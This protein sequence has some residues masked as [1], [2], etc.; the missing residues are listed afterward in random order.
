MVRRACVKL[1]LLVTFLIIVASPPAAG[2]QQSETPLDLVIVMDNSGSMDNEEFGEADP[3]GLR[4]DAAKMLID[5]LS[6]EDR[7]GLVQ[8]SDAATPLVEALK[9]LDTVEQRTTL[10]DVI[11]EADNEDPGNLTNYGVALAAAYELL[12]D[13]SRNQR[14]VIFL[15]DGLPSD[16]QDGNGQV[17][18]AKLDAALAPFK[19]TN[20]PVYLLLLENKLFEQIQDR[21]PLVL[22]R[23]E[24]TGASAVQLSQ[25]IDTAR[26]FAY[27]ITQLQPSTY[28]DLLTGDPE[29]ATTT[30][31][32]L[33]SSADQA[34]SQA[35]FVFVPQVPQSA[36][37]ATPLLE[38]SNSQRL[39]A[40]PD[41]NYSVVKYESTDNRPLEGDWQFSVN[42]QQVQGFA[43]VRSDVRLELVY[44][45]ATAEGHRYYARDQ[46]LFTAAR[47]QGSVI[48][49]DSRMVIRILPGK[50]CFVLPAGET[51]TVYPLTARGLSTDASLFWGII[52]P[53]TG[54]V[55]VV[56]EFQQLDRPLRLTRCAVIRRGPGIDGALTILHPLPADPLQEGKIPLGV[57]IPNGVS[58]EQPTAFVESPAGNVESVS[59]EGGSGA[60]QNV[61]QAGTYTV[62]YLATGGAE[63]EQPVTLF[64][65]TQY[66]VVRSISGGESIE[67]GPINALNSPLQTP[68]QVEA[69][70][71]TQQDTLTFQVLSIQNKTTGETVDPAAIEVDLC[72]Q[73][74]ILPGVLSC[75]IS[76][77][78]NPSLAQGEYEIEVGITVAN[79]EGGPGPQPITIGFE[80]PASALVNQGVTDDNESNTITPENQSLHHLLDFAPRL[81]AGDPHLTASF[82]SL[83]SLDDRRTLPEPGR[84][85]TLDLIP[86]V[87]ESTYEYELV[88]QDTGELPEGDYEARIRLVP[89]A[90]GLLV[91]PD[92][93]SY[94]FNKRNAYV[95]ISTL[96]SA[97]PL[98]YQ[99]T[100]WALPRSINAVISRIPLLR[101][102][103]PARIAYP[104]TLSTHYFPN[105]PVLPPAT[106]LSISNETGTVQSGALQPAWQIDR[107]RGEEQYE[108][109]MVLSAVEAIEAGDYNVRLRFPEPIVEP[110]EVVMSVA[111]ADV[112]DFGQHLGL[113][114]GAVLLLAFLVWRFGDERKKLHGTLMIGKQ[115]V[116]L[117]GLRS[118][119]S[120]T[121]QQ[122][123][124]VARPA[125]AKSTVIVHRLD[126][127]RIRV[128][129]RKRGA[130]KVLKRGSRLKKPEIE[131]L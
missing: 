68:I 3:T 61:E 100:I 75:S 27:L 9:L 115:A 44:P 65:E 80:R 89:E 102:W 79:V 46:P 120:I 70:F 77:L 57:A 123:Q 84:Y 42:G 14:A 33:Y 52:P 82:I 1:W 40:P 20:I 16:M 116:R 60:A 37:S 66:V 59:L 131:Y 32:A 114:M 118:P 129:F 130:S 43:F 54:D 72:A 91:E 105:E 127:N 23:F 111:V 24:T 8:F 30:R 126:R 15:T 12:N 51:G 7:I 69:Q 78:P 110:E 76:I 95:E 36:F 5:L 17:D 71:V 4:Y 31:F 122:D 47:P 96:I 13:D 62:R 73:P 86:P 50:D 108:G 45:Q 10:K 94:T 63:A 56:L 117:E 106:V 121:K 64:A 67:L 81:W 101:D 22:D 83:R 48:G 88:M 18:T 87:D 53:V 90:E 124:F 93:Y 19:Q 74:D 28:L 26:A 29:T 92:E 38:P 21:V 125:D 2:A 35:S 25:P 11:Q 58:W 103:Y 85:L 6:P 39:E 128:D 112:W 97:E 113:R 49:P 99:S 41:P 107:A 119:V 98:S 109:Q 34:V 104:V 55:A